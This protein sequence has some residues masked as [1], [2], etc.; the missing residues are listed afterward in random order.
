MIKI[1]ILC[2]NE[3]NKIARIGDNLGFFRNVAIY[4]D[5]SG[6]YGYVKSPDFR[7]IPTI[8]DGLIELHR[9]LYGSDFENDPESFLELSPTGFIIKA[10]GTPGMTVMYHINDRHR[11]RS[12]G[13]I[14]L[15]GETELR[16][17]DRVRFFKV[18]G[19]MNGTDNSYLVFDKSEYVYKGRPILVKVMR[20]YVMAGMGKND[21]WFWKPA[22]TAVVCLMNEQHEIE[23]ARVTNEDGIVTFLNDGL[24]GFAPG[25]Y[26]LTIGEYTDPSFNCSLYSAPYAEVTI[27]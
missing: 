13:K 14:G 23:D 22:H 5:N 26:Y 12:D 27:P 7:N 15:I 18:F 21:K 11:H 8:L 4:A 25:H 24:E 16:E 2:S 9:L 17:G 20:K 19:P 6:K 10:F 3:P 1:N